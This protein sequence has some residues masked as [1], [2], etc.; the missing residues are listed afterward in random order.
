MTELERSMSFPGESPVGKKIRGA[1]QVP[2]TILG[3]AE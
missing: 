2:S 3:S 1:G